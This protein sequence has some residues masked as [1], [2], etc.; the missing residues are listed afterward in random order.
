VALAVAAIAHTAAGPQNP[1]LPARPAELAPGTGAVSGVI[2]DATTHQPIEGVNIQLGPPPSRVGRMGNQF[3]DARGRFAFAD[4]SPG[5][6][7][8]NAIKAGYGD[9]HFAAGVLGALGGT[10]TIADGEWF[11]EANIEMPRLGAIGGRVF[12]ERGEPV[13]GAFVRV[14]SRFM[15]AGTAQLASGPTAKTDDLGEY[16]IPGLSAGKYIVMAPSVQHSA[17]TASS[18]ADI[19][20]LTADQ[21][22]AQEAQ[23]A[24]TGGPPP[25][26]RNGGALVDGLTALIL[27]NYVIPPPPINGRM[28]AYAPVFYP[29]VATIDASTPVEVGPGTEKSG[30]D[31]RLQPVPAARVS[32][33]LQGVSNFAGYVV[34]LLPPGLEDLGQGSEVATAIVAPD[35]SFTFLG[36]PA[37]NY[38]L[39]APGSSFEY[40]VRRAAV[41]VLDGSLPGTPGLGRGGSS[42]GSIGGLPGMGSNSVK[43]T[44]IK[45]E[46]A[47]FVRLP[48]AVGES[49]LTDLAVPL[50]R[51]AAVRGQ[52]V[53][54]D[55]TGPPPT[56]S[57]EISGANGSAAL[58]VH[59]VSAARPVDASASFSVP[60]LAPGEYA[61]RMFNG[62]GLTI[63][64]ITVDGNDYSRKPFA[65]TVGQDSA[66]TLTMTGK[67]IKLSG[68]VRDAKGAPVPQASV[69]AFPTD[70]SLWTNYGVSPSWIRPSV[71]TSNGTYTI[72]SIRA[73]EY[74]LVGVDLSRI[75][76]W[77]DPAF[78][79]SAVPFATR[80]SFD[81][82]D[83]KILDVPLMVKK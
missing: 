59:F 61:L 18:V 56:V 16:R 57:F 39:M 72:A 11:S 19:E 50:Q 4:V 32:G 22:A 46:H 28:R 23:A 3:T 49:D 36:V 75:N 30:I 83:T 53:F 82:G 64:A 6:Y 55:V 70:R 58:G 40:S 33:R 25:V 43:P 52:V 2:T 69:I 37:G 48:I 67:V 78:L 17:P 34:R 44:T 7:F 51:F 71:G 62:G 41:G 77:V 68:V 66:L 81:W 21:L 1:A 47:G 65:V 24:R 20:G 73:G 13:A 10:I 14:L 27:G 79:A 26:R 63:K 80:V 60:L 42:G 15:L 54:E 38:T 76:A 74:Y 8:I 31:L 12:D 45:D 5:N 35:G 9:G 29:G